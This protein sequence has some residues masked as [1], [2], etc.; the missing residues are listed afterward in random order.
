[1]SATVGVLIRTLNEAAL[2]GRC[3]ET[4]AHQ[5]GDH[6]LDVL[7]LDSGSTDDTLAIA[8]AHGAR[9]YEM[10]PEDFD[11]SRSLNIGI[12]ELAGDIILILSA[13]AIPLDEEW[14][15]RM[16]APFADPRRRRRDQP[17]GALARA[18]VPRGAPAGEHIRH[19]AAHVV[20][21]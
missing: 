15:A 20:G 17:P 9:I 7:V 5:Q 13:H 18:P 19:G 3:L 8:R 10:A 6:E 1:M 14:V 11:Y 2:L 4:L 12:A 21:G 16:T